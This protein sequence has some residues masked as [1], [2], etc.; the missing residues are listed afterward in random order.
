VLSLAYLVT[1][2]RAGRSA[3]VSAAMAAERSAHYPR[4]PEFEVHE[5]SDHLESPVAARNRRSIAGGD[6]LTIKARSIVM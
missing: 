3:R 4:M 1:G 2:V 5:A 6:H